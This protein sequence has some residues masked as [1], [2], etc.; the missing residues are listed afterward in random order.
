MNCSKLRI[1]LASVVL[2]VLVILFKKEKVM[3]FF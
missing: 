2:K 3:N 1:A